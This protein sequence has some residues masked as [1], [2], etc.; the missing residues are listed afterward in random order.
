MI[1]EW[2]L[3]ESKQLFKDKWANIKQETWQ[4]PNG[5][6]IA[7]FYKY[8]F[9]NYTCAV[10]ITKD[11][12]VILE[13]I[14]RQGLGVIANELP[15]GC[16]N[17]NED[18]KDTIAR[19]LKEETGYAFENIDFLGITSPNPTTNT[20]LMYMFLAT[21]GE[22]KYQAKLDQEEEVE[23][24]EVSINEMKRMLYNDEFIQAMQCTAIYKALI[25]LNLIAL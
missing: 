4:Q 3:I 20:N 9:P 23:V 11:G 1:K 13:K 8:G 15:G 18:P 14:F 7:P 21:G 24:F 22:K 25:K 12:K 17:E 16:V 2:K 6:I 5:Q 10:A 19:E